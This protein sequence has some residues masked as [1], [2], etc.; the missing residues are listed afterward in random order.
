MPS[1]W[2]DALR[3]VGGVYLLTDE[4]DGRLY[5][6][7]AHGTDG[8]YGRWMEHATNPDPIERGR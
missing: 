3:L 6:G 8:F 7:A 4:P 2:Q 1:A 5:V